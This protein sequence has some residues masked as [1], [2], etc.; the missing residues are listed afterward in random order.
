MPD[1]APPPSEESDSESNASERKAIQAIGAAG[2]EPGSSPNLMQLAAS[3]TQLATYTLILGAAGYA[4]DHFRGHA[5][6]WFAIAGSLVGFTLGM[7]RLIVL[8]IRS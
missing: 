3:G 4:I 7:Y 2:L 8:A 5:I 6:P 1:A